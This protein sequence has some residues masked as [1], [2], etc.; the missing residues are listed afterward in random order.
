M[1]RGGL[2][3]RFVTLSAAVLDPAAHLVTLVNAGGMNPLLYRAATAALEE[4]ISNDQSGLPLGVMPGFEYESVTRE[5]EPGDTITMFTDGVT[6]AMSPPGQLFGMEGVLKHLTLDEPTTGTLARPSWIGER[7][8]QAV[9]RHA[10]GRP[11]N[12]DIAVVCFGRLDAGIGPMT[13]TTKAGPNTPT[14]PIQ[15]R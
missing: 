10:N 15:L 7:L 3:D 13:K 5:L 1:I 4:A 2:G 8:V 11:Q 12:D 14:T 9:K 6:D